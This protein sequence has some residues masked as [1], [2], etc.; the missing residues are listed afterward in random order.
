MALNGFGLLLLFALLLL[1]LGL[2]VALSPPQ[3][4][5]R[6]LG[7][8]LGPTGEE[9]LLAE[10]R[11]RAL[12]QQQIGA[13]GF[14]LLL[15]RGYLEIP[16]P[17]LPDRTYRIPYTHGMVEVI[18]GGLATMRLC[19]VPTRWVPDC[20]LVIMHKLL[21]EGD[22]ARYLRVANRFP[23]AAARFMRG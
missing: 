13:E 1:L 21:I 4:L 18:E 12:L 15:R 3:R 16:S 5:L 6:R 10:Q 19:I 2:I 11:A 7:V 23:T 9:R 20:D 8:S 22:E 14:A 17:S